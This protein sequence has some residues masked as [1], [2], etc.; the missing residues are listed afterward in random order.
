M[1]PTP[2]TR[3]VRT[4]AAG[5][6][7]CALGAAT[8]TVTGTAH[9]DDPDPA[10][11]AHGLPSGWQPRGEDHPGTVTTTDLAIPMSDGVVLRGDLTLPADAAGTA[12]AGRF[13]TIVEITAYNKTFLAQGGLGGADAAY[14][15]KRGYAK[16]TVD[17]RGTGSSPGEWEAF[18]ARENKD[19]GEIVEWAHSQS[20]STGSV[21]MTGPSYMGI[22]Q[23]FAAE[24]QPAGLKAIFPQV[25]AHD[26]YRDIVASGGAID[27]GFI[28]LWLGLVNGT[29]MFPT[30]FQSDPQAAGETLADHVLGLFGFT[31]PLIPD[32]L[33]G[34]EPAYDGAFYDERSPRTDLDK[35][36]VPAFFIGGEYDLFQRG[37]PMDFERL[38]RNGVP[39]KLI[40]GPWNHLRGSSGEAIADA[41][42][43]TLSELQLRWFDHYVR[44][45]ADPALDTDIPP[46]TYYEQGTGQWRTSQKWIG[47]QLRATTYNLSGSASTG[48]TMGALTTG[49]PQ[50]GTADVHPVPA[51]GL[52][53]RSATQWTAGLTDLIPVDN[54]CNTDSSWNDHLGVVF[55]TAPLANP[56]AIQGPINAHLFVS[57]TGTDGLLSVAV[58]DEAP[59]GTVSRLTGG[60][61]VLSHRALDT[62]RSRY[63]G[64]TLIQPWHPFTEAA[65]QPMSGVQAIDVE[66]FPTG[67][68]ILPGH[69]LRISIQGA[70]SPHALQPLGDLLGTGVMTI[71]ASAQYPSSITLP[72]VV[73]QRLST[74]TVPKLKY[75]TTKVGQGNRVDVTV[76]GGSTPT[77]KVAVFVNGVQ[78]TTVPLAGGKAA[79]ALPARK[80]GGK[81]TVLVKY[82][83]DAYHLPS[84]AR[85]TWT[86]VP[87]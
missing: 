70:D 83:G 80:G 39:T 69:R 44:G 32:A 36:T 43:G 17:A 33:T 21:G 68:R 75:A 9:A 53:S 52:C 18:G 3:L 2:A 51:A 78:L 20:W 14:L 58:E 82:L 49:A 62:S 7:T 74:T 27:V 41:G 31:V 23:L 19:A 47:S 79:V 12:I 73:P 87:R 22:S 45:L 30:V 48:Q 56:V 25:P 42:Y 35:I 34:G 81:V 64:G 4:L 37:T 15:V 29:A 13:P 5:A 54:P 10:P 16:L 46:L 65:Q 24:G 66:I 11:V 61:Q 63:L 50:S 76:A 6:L 26:V 55:R 40:I 72:T 67:A 85:V 84:Q 38:Q 1:R 8:L 59:D 86:V 57:T 71:H 77:G 28:P 60:W